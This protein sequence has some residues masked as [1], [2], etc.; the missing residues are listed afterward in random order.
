MQTVVL[1]APKGKYRVVGTDTF[2]SP[3]PPY[4]DYLIG[5][6]ASLDEAKH[7]ADDK[8]A[9]MNLVYVYDATGKTLYRAG[10]F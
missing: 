9:A 6:Y 7:V 10:S 1:K 2:E 8:G 5:D 3:S 4:A